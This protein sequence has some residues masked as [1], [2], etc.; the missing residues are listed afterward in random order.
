VKGIQLYKKVR[1]LGSAAL[2]LVYVACGRADVYHENDIA[3]WDVAA[4]IAI[5]LGAGGKVN[6]CPTK[7]KN[8]LS[9][10]AGNNLLL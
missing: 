10:K 8:K 5:V 6:V 4:G 1:L 2:S 9:V 7:V 3:I